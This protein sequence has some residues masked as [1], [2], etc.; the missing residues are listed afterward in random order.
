MLLLLL[1]FVL[2]QCIQRAKPQWDPSDPREIARRKSLSE[3]RLASFKIVADTVAREE[4][5]KSKRRSEGQL[6]VAGLSANEHQVRSGSL[7]NVPACKG[8]LMD[9]YISCMII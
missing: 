3:E 1:L 6:A 5:E 2:L 4:A 8:R 9:R 7:C